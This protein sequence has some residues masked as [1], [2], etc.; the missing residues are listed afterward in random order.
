MVSGYGYYY[1]L[2]EYIYRLRRERDGQVFTLVECLVTTSGFEK[3][4]SLYRGTSD[5]SHVGF[6]VGAFA[7]STKH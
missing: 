3:N 1:R 4:L 5:R 6:F 2:F 7:H